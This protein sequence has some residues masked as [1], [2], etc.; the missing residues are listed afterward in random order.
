MYIL[1]FASLH[2]G[3][4]RPRS[5]LGFAVLVRVYY[6]EISITRITRALHAEYISRQQIDEGEIYL[7]AAKL[8]YY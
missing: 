1:C 4:S 5:L 3:L 6:H 8:H 7:A 2:S